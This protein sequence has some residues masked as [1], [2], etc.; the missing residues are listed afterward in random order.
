ML[1]LLLLDAALKSN[2]CMKHTTGRGCK[3]AEED[4]ICCVLAGSSR[5]V[6]ECICGV[7]DWMN[8]S[9]C[10]R[11]AYWGSRQVGL[12]RRRFGETSRQVLS[13]Q[14]EPVDRLRQW[15]E[16]LQPADFNHS[17]RG[18]I[19]LIGVMGWPIKLLENRIWEGRHDCGLPC[20]W[21]AVFT[22]QPFLQLCSV[23]QKRAA[24]V[25]ICFVRF[26]LSIIHCNYV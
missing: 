4:C 1:L 21:R 3:L 20:F 17:I 25:A 10:L 11:K 19:Q 2:C 8:L 18:K 22:P 12:E 26:F 16:L 7:V 24:C 5:L 14:F 15:T 6:D 9:T 13:T 23:I